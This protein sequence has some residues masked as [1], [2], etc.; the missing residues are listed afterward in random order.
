LAYNK[1]NVLIRHD[2]K[3]INLDN[4][5]QLHVHI[6]AYMAREQYIAALGQ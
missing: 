3:R 2:Y 4:V 6:I 1:S 5:P